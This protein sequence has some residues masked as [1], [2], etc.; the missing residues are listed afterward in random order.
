MTLTELLEGR[1]RADVRFRG[2]AYF[3][4]E[5]VAI[6]RV[7]PN[8][9]FAVVRDGVEY[10]TQ[11]SRHDGRLRLY[12]NCAKTAQTDST[13]K[14]LWATVL[15]TDEGS[16]ISGEIKAD[17]VPPFVS[18]SRL[19]SLSAEI[20]DEDDGP[21]DFFE[22]PSGGS[23]QPTLSIPVVAS[24]W[25]GRLGQLRE[26]L[27]QEPAATS[28]SPREQEI[29]YEIDIDQSR[30]VGQIVIQ[31]S[32]RQHRGNGQWGKLKP[33][34]LR[35]GRLDDLIEADDARIL[36]Y[37]SG[38][39]P[40]RT[41]WHAQ[42]AEIQ[43]SVHRFRVPHELC[44]LIMP[45]MCATGRVRFLNSGEKASTVLEWDNGPPWNSRCESFPTRPKRTGGSKDSF[46]A[47][48]KSCR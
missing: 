17:H 30:S 1:F 43:N 8:E 14:H 26:T 20:A 13:C 24:G 6:A 42:Q 48:M 44:E 39:T 16:Y 41:N 47:K 36:A 18:E 9:L 22:P 35:A 38:G 46:A 2:A 33:L 12:C 19:R 29:F 7:T 3:K 5:R 28:A 25:Q 37:L 23:A 15:A 10:Q 32:H 11:L 45:L 21:G 4:A 31:T 34:R 40:E 27:A